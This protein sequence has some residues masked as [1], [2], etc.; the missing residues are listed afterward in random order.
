MVTRTL[1]PQKAP[2]AF[3]PLPSLRHLQAATGL[4]S[5]TRGGFAFPGGHQ[6]G[7][8][9]TPRKQF[10]GPGRVACSS[11]PAQGRGSPPPDPPAR[12]TP[13]PELGRGRWARSSESQFT[14]SM[15]DQVVTKDLPGYDEQ[16]AEDTQRAGLAGPQPQQVLSAWVCGAPPS[17]HVGA[18]RSPAWKLSNPVL[19]GFPGDAVLEILGRG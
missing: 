17:W 2:L 3:V 9:S 12:P 7:K 10:G 13:L 4:R 14:H 1:S 15:D 5:A 11:T 18:S 6:K 19:L 16:L 8:L